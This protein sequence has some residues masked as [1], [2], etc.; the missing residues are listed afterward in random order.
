LNR[1][2]ITLLA[3]ALTLAAALASV[4][5]VSAATSRHIEGRVLSID[6]TGRS[7]RL[8]DSERG[9][10]RVYVRSA[11][12]FEGTSF[13]RLRVGHHLEATVRRVNHRWQA[14]SVERR[15]ARSSH[16]GGSD[17]SGSGRHGGGSDDGAGHH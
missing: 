17:D 1:R 12:K 10:Y 4:G 11:T 3:A 14:S 6:H 15:S 5:P 9:T 2:L 7:F 16:G 13:T 8:R